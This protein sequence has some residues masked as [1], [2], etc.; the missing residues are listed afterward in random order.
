VNFVTAHDGFTLHDLVSYNE[1][2]NEANGEGNRDGHNNNLSWNCG[3]EGE[4]DD[5]AILTLR[6]R[7]KRNLL[8]SLLLSQGVPMLLAGDERGHTQN[9][10]NNAYC[11]DNQ[12]GWLDWT[13]TPERESLTTF[14][15]RVIGLRRAHP[16]FRRRNFF[17]GRPI[18]GDTIK[19]ASWLRPDGEEMTG[20]DWNE[21]E[22]RCL[23]M[24]VSGRGI[25]ERGPRGETLMDDDF[26]L[27]F[28]SHHGDIP[29]VL[30]AAGPAG[31]AVLI[32]TATNAMPPEG[33][34]P[35]A[36]SPP[37]WT[38]ATYPLQARSFALLSRAASHL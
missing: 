27:L 31:W 9:G 24:L 4:T 34:G 3:T 15:Q 29:F 19:D 23:A 26:L 36:P 30:P 11:Q 8:A 18:E 37:A 5:P 20:A 25:S 13:S 38:E 1:K 10:N 35:F 17:V 22:A 28:N 2:H 12:L 16:S 7:Q 6:E 21:S 14:V 33:H 32:D